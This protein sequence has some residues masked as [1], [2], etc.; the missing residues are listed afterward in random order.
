MQLYRTALPALLA[1]KRAGSMSSATRSLLRCAHAS[2]ALRCIAA[3][4]HAVPAS[5]WHRTCTECL[6]APLCLWMRTRPPSVMLALSRMAPLRYVSSCRT[7]APA[8]CSAC[9]SALLPSP[10][11]P[12]CCSGSTICSTAS[13]TC[14]LGD[15][16][17]YQSVTLCTRTSPLAWPDSS[18]VSLRLPNTEAIA[19]TAE[20]APVSNTGVVRGSP[21][22][23]S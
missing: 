7:A 2:M 11:A 15:S 16:A 9:C 3:P 1:S 14:A 10:A 8:S 17:V 19:V 18:V 4:H 23:W 6:T 5:N 12:G 22:V 20:P 13:S 21:G